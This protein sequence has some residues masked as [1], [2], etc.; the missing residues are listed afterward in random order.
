MDAT[1]DKLIA[2]CQR[3]LPYSTRSFEVLLRRH[4]EVIFKTCQRYL[5]DS[6]D[7]EDA[8][9]DVFMRVFHGLKKFRGE[10]TF[11]TWLYR[12]VANVC[13]TRY[14]KKKKREERMAAFMEHSGRKLQQQEAATGQRKIGPA[15]EALEE[16][17]DAER[18][19]I[20]L[21]HSSGLS[22]PEIAEIVGVSLSAA[23][24]RLSRAEKRMKQAYQALSG[25]TSE[26][27]PEL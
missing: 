9:Q 23:K 17:A 18:E 21:R 27:D 8:A 22:V 12:I 6:T 10:A 7:A 19:I 11:K 26:K 1:D 15:Q 13:A 24:M 5:G 16:L 4:E 2:Q 25:K 14:T 20:V 3:E